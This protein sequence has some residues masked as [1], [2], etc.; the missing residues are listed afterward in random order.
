V[1]LKRTLFNLLAPPFDR[2]CG[3]K[4]ASHK[5]LFIVGHGRSGT[6]WVGRT[7]SQHPGVLY[8]NEP[9]HFGHRSAE[10]RY[11]NFFSYVTANG[12]A[13]PY[14]RHLDAAMSGRSLRK[15]AEWLMDHRKVGR[16]LL[17]PY[18]VVVKEVATIMSVDWI[19]SEYA[20]DFL[21][22]FRH[23]CAVALSE[24][25]QG[26]DVEMSK[27][28]L[29]G[30]T[31]LFADHLG[32]YET[33]IRKAVRPYE[34][35]G[36]VYGARN[37]ILAN[38]VERHRIE[39]VLLYEELSRDPLQVFAR[40]FGSFGL[41]MPQEVKT[42]VSSTTS[43]EIG[44]LYGTTK[45][46]AAHIARWKQVLTAEEALQVRDFVLPFGLPWYGKADEYLLS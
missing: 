28:K 26:I 42:Y 12:H 10:E 2:L 14:K 7:F 37:R 5:P 24:L 45:D 38:F 15:S 18:R 29:L 30:L 39:T 4:P 11:E 43:T 41:D 32:P 33:L 22:L 35:F 31:R 9:C 6:T 40:L 13:G 3:F 20:P 19:R 21:V 1:S 25:Q 44:G 17:G 8:Y 27:R 23:P 46:S 36:A 16:R 34:I